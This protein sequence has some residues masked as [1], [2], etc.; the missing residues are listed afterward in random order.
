MVQVSLVVLS[1]ADLLIDFVSDLCVSLSLLLDQLEDVQLLEAL[2]RFELFDDL[3]A[4]LVGVVTAARSDEK[5]SW[6]DAVT[7]LR[8][9]LVKVLLG[10]DLLQACVRLKVWHQSLCV[11]IELTDSLRQNGRRLVRAVCLSERSH[12]L[13]AQILRALESEH[14]RRRDAIL[15][16]ELSLEFTLWEVFDQ[17][18]WAN[19][20][21]KVVDQS[22]SL[23][24]IIIISQIV[25]LNELI[26]VQKLHVR[27]LAES[28]A[29]SCLA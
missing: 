12:A 2:G 26:V 28:C 20:L 13:L 17:D 4:F 6:L 8:E 14:S 22:H 15:H 25:F 29:Q 19:F 23:L 7:E 9:S 10:V 16:E 18:S 5:D 3:S 21:S 11:L 24:L 1:C 27:A